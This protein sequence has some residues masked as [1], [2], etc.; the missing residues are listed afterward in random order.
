MC[1]EDT[2]VMMP[3]GEM[4]S[5]VSG[6]TPTIVRNQQPVL[7]LAIEQNIGI[8]STYRRRI[9]QANRIDSTLLSN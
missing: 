5:N 8:R 1:F 3:G 7:A 4:I 9:R 6:H 2:P